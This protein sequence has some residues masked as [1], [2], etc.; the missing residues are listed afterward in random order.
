MIPIKDYIYGAFIL[1]LL[2]GFG[3]YTI[4]ERN[5]GKQEIRAA[6][7]RA[8]IAQNIHD[9]EVIKRASIIA[10]AG[11][12]KYKATLAS[13]P[14]T[15]VPNNWVC[16]KPSGTKGM[17]TIRPPGSPDNV[18]PEESTVVRGP[19]PPEIDK[20]FGD[21]DGKVRALQAYITACQEAGRCAR[22]Q[23][24]Y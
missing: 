5:I 16:D 15:N 12:S 11:I 24:D 23:D 1:I 2:M 8:V 17:P 14:S 18:P 6:D 20:R 4:H 13:P 7:Q 10:K 21:D 9:S 3:W 19:I 22:G